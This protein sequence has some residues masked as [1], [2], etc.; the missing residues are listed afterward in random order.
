[1]SKDELIRELSIALA[2]AREVIKCAVPRSE[3]S[4]WW[5][6][7]ARLLQVAKGSFVQSLEKNKTEIPLGDARGRRSL[8][9]RTP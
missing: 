9:V 6:R 4:E 8:S 3:T 2:D 5:R 7:D 1:M